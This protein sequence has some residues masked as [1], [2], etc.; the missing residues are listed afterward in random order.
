VSR[1]LLAAAAALLAAAAAPAADPAKIVFVAGTTYYKPGEHDYVAGC[2]L[3]ADLAKQTPGVSPVVARDWPTPAELAGAKA[4]VLFLDGGDKHPLR[5]GGRLAEV[6][7]VLD[8]GGGL[9]LLHQMADVPADLGDRLRGLAGGAWE[10]GRGQRAHWVATF[11]RFPPHPVF[12]GVSAFTIDDGWLTHNRFADGMT[13]VTPL[14]RT[15]NPKA[16][17]TVSDE[18]AVVGWAF[19]RPA[20]GR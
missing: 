6:T 3:L 12:R 4:V 16:K 7:K 11:D 13:G 15:A 14:L 18:E 17:G 8:A 1:P 20:G 9:V 5:E 10:K 2:R 19:D